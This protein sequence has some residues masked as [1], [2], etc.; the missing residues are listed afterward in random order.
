MS[1]LKE[2]AL[3]LLRTNPEL[4]YVG[5]GY[6][7][8]E[9]VLDTNSEEVVVLGVDQKLPKHLLYNR[10]ALPTAFNQWRTDVQE[11]NDPPTSS[12]MDREFIQTNMAKHYKESGGW[13]GGSIS[14]VFYYKGGPVVLTNRHVAVLHDGDWSLDSSNATAH[15]VFEVLDIATENI[16]SAIFRVREG[17]QS[18]IQPIS[19]ISNV[20]IAPSPG[21][22]CY[23][24]SGARGTPHEGNIISTGWSI[25]PD[26]T[27]PDGVYLTANFR[28]LN[29][30]GGDAS[31][32]SG[33]SGSMV[34]SDV[35]KSDGSLNL[36]GVMGQVF[37]GGGRT[38]YCVCV[39]MTNIMDYWPELTFSK[40][41]PVET[42]TTG[43][44]SEE[45][46]RIK[47]RTAQSKINRLTR[48]LEDEQ[49]MN[50]TNR[51]LISKLEEEASEY[52]EKYHNIFLKYRNYKK[53]II[54]KFRQINK[55]SY[56]N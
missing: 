45:D 55:E 51:E 27:Q 28:M 49:S 43:F 19:G 48:S 47:L 25:Q 30:T 52:K 33:D 53:A 17:R 14:P 5:K 50:E 37:A 32:V 15:E 12:L 16:D 46:W 10:K 18:Y 35:N 2:L 41:P 40:E 8:K 31:P 23:Y 36:R 44:N 29:L 1:E 3:E 4:T 7:E 22:K 54:D 13:V 34:Y 56:D 9:G 21:I 24:V 38:K 6:R 20:V 26:N 39:P 11:I 42:V